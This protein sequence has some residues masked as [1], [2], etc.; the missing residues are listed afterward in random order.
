MR[1]PHSVG[2][3]QERRFEGPASC[4]RGS[5]GFRAFFA[6]AQ[7]NYSGGLEQALQ[8]LAERRGTTIRDRLAL[9]YRE[10]RIVFEDISVNAVVV[11]DPDFV[12]ARQLKEPFLVAAYDRSMKWIKKKKQGAV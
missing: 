4:V 5:C 10:S 3:R 1:L 7:T 12:A 11:I 8:D 9:L 2:N 6:A